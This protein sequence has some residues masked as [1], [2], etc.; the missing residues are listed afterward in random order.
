MCIGV[1]SEVCP[2]CG[3]NGKGH[4]PYLQGGRK[5]IRCP[6]FIKSMTGKEPSGPKC[7]SIMRDQIGKKG[8]CA[9]CKSRKTYEQ[10]KAEGK[11]TPNEQRLERIRL[12]KERFDKDVKTKRKEL[13]GDQ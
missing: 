4:D 6:A 1:N 13:W 5:W 2:D 10:R 12:A 9:V 8:D 11:M 7:E 3:N